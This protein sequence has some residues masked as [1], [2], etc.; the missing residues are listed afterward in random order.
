MDMKSRL[1]AVV[2]DRIEKASDENLSQD[3]KEA[4]F[5]EAMKATDRFIELC[6][7]KS[8][9]DKK[10]DKV[11]KYVEL[12]AVPLAL[13]TV[14]FLFKMRFTK[15]VCNFEKDYTFTTRAGQSV[16]QFFKFRK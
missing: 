6:N 10:W 3:E 1:E 14:E 2:K 4:A 16:S 15:T 13:A 7:V 5:E 11:L 9:K 8:D 12:F